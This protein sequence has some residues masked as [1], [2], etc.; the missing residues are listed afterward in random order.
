MGKGARTLIFIGVLVG[1]NAASY[2]FD[3]GFWLW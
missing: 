1:V 3:W 2:L